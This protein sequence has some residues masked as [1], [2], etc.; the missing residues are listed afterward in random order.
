MNDDAEAG[1]IGLGGAEAA[2]VVELVRTADDNT[3]GAGA[4]GGAV[5][6][7]G[8][9]LKGGNRLTG[10]DVG[11][12]IRAGET[13]GRIAPL[14]RPAGRHLRAGN[15][16]PLVRRPRHLDRANVAQGTGIFHREGKHS[17]GGIVEVLDLGAG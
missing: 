5:Q 8:F 1:Q 2:G 14:R 12:R 7:G 16:A 15:D 9:H 3:P 4:V 11:G 10:L 6:R 17:S 13:A